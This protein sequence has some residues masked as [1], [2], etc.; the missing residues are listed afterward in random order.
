MRKTAFTA[1]LVVA[2]AT[3][4]RADPFCDIL[5]GYIHDAPHNAVVT[6]TV[7]RGAVQVMEAKVALPGARCQVAGYNPTGVEKDHPAEQS[8]NCRWSAGEDAYRKLFSETNAH[9]AQCLGN[10]MLDDAF[11][12]RL[13]YQTNYGSIR[14][15]ADQMASDW[16][17][18]VTVEPLD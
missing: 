2:F 10:P 8:V 11:A 15:A 3:E 4:A 12:L 6:Q 18:S 16:D 5:M 7:Q 9:V 14:V 17:V 13:E 1:L